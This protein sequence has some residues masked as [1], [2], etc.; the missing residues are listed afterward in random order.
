M[1]MT[2]DRMRTTGFSPRTAALTA[3]LVLSACLA[4]AQS[5][6]PTVTQNLL[7]SV[8]PTALAPGGPAGSYVLSGFENINPA[9]GHLSI[10]LPL[11]QVGGRGQAGYT[12]ML[13]LDQPQWSVESETYSFSDSVNTQETWKQRPVTRGDLMPWRPG[14]GPGVV[15]VKHTDANPQ[16]CTDSLPYRLRYTDTLTYIVFREPDGTEHALYDTLTEGAPITEQSCQNP[17]TSRGTTFV[18]RDGSGLT[19]TSSSSLVD[20]RYT[21][22]GRVELPTGLLMKPD[23]TLY[24]ATGGYVTRIRDRNGNQST[25][26]Y[27]QVTINGQLTGTS[28]LKKIIDPLGRQIDIAYDLL[29]GAGI[30]YDQ[31]SFKGSNGQTRH[32]KVKKTVSST[33]LPPG[34]TDPPVNVS[35]LFPEMLSSGLAGDVRQAGGLSVELEN[36]QSY[37]FYRN[38][39]GEVDRVVLPTGGF[40]DYAYGPGLAVDPTHAI[41][42]S[43]QVFDSSNGILRRACNTDVHGN[44]CEAPLAD[45]AP[46]L[47]VIY[48]RLLS[49]SVYPNGPG[50]PEAVTTY[51]LPETVSGAP[52]NAVLTPPPCLYDL[53]DTITGPSVR[54]AALHF[55]DVHPVVVTKS[56][57]NATTVSETHY[58]FGE[59]SDRMPPISWLLYLR[60][61]PVTPPAVFAGKEYK[62][63]ITGYSREETLWG[64]VNAQGGLTAKPCQVN[65]SLLDGA[66]A[67]SSAKVFGYD[68]FE[69]TTD[70]YEYDYSAFASAPPIP[71]SSRQTT[72]CAAPSTGSGYS[73]QTHTDFVTNSSYTGTPHLWRLPSAESVRNGSG[74]IISQ[75]TYSYDGGSLTSYGSM[76]GHNDTGITVRGN[77]TSIVKSS[78]TTALAYDVAGS[79]VKTT[80][81]RGVCREIGYADNGTGGGSTYAFP[82]SVTTYTGLN[83]TGTPLTAT[84]KWDYNI[85]KPSASIDVNGQQTSY[86]YNDPLDRLKNITRP[87]GGGTTAFDYVDSPGALSLTT[88]VSQNASSSIASRV[89]Y[90]GMGRKVRAIQDGACAD[91]GDATTETIYD[92]MGRV[93]QVSNP[94]CPGDS[95]V[96]TTTAYDALGRVTSVTAPGGAVTTTAYSGNLATVIDP[97]GVARQSATD[98]LGRV[99]QVVEN[100]NGSLSYTTFY[101]YDLLDDL[102]QV[103]QGGALNSSGNCTNAQAGVPYQVRT[104]TYDSLKRLLSATNPEL[105]GRSHPLQLRPVTSFTLLRPPGRADA[106]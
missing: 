42:A 65:T 76:T 33:Y 15:V 24:E 34:H 45:R 54:I 43:G 87:S 13:S 82:T 30:E 96:Y 3:L 79:V 4:M 63:E 85:G 68:A 75:T 11:L 106:C 22:S 64:L 73:R 47:P 16:P 94:Y 83:C 77:V 70:V 67:V 8:T 81:P 95:V 66:S 36:G 51:S 38:K 92:G 53:C 74:G 57:I 5:D 50:T 10:A 19:F 31:I 29:D 44:G 25:F 28:L 99:T 39:Y 2:N 46:S 98:A 86:A 1:N 55:D 72:P 102:V 58:F 18:A 37:Q 71:T 26:E 20:R 105:S 91:G 48:R 9:S 78:L 61:H 40:I 80:D 69:N 59:D 41:Y 23:G 12:M 90:D 21:T 14:Y 84:T 6:E 88:T 32:V 27:E 103:C 100:P 101:S 93:R 97:A 62:T 60:D 52:I 56:G 89:E 7:D 104:F 49:R 35:E 17:A